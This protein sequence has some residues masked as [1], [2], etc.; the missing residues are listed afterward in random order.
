M[1]HVSS[2]ELFAYWNARR[3]PRLVPDR[4]D[5][6]PG[7]I[8][9]VLSDTFILAADAKAGHPFR[10]AGTRIC[11]LFCRELKGE[12]FAS[13]WEQDGHTEMHARVGIVA[14]ESIGL[15]ASARARNAEGAVLDLELVLLPLAWRGNPRARIIGTLVPREAPYWLGVSPITSLTLGSFRHLDAELER[16]APLFVS[17]AMADKLATAAAVAPGRI[18]SPGTLH[19]L[20]APRLQQHGL[21]VYEGG[22]VE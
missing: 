19:S 8:R 12:T 3:G 7:A 14:D 16:N 1:K 6:E 15:V 10:L 11:A 17:G 18:S 21:R 5:I 9:A 2:Q 20:P 4:G 13:L 22:R